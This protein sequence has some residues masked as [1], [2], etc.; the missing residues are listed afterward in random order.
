MQRGCLARIIGGATGRNLP[1]PASGSP[2]AHNNKKFYNNVRKPSLR[3]GG[4]AS[5][6]ALARHSVL[7][8]KVTKNTHHKNGRCF[9]ELLAGLEPA[10]C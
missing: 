4:K 10:T 6:R 8:V 7:A 3:S 2:F 1:F 9:L 5:G